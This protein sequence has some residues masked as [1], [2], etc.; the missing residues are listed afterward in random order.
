M[1]SLFPRALALA[2]VVAAG[3]ASAAI[4]LFGHDGFHGARVTLDAARAR[5]PRVRLQR[6]RV[7]G[8]RRGRVL[9]GLPGR[10]LPQPLRDPRAGQLPQPRRRRPGRP[11]VVRAPDAPQPP[12]PPP[13]CRR[14]RRSNDGD[15]V[16]FE[17]PGFHGR[18]LAVNGEI[19][20]M[21]QY[22]FNDR[23]SSVIVFEDRWE[24]CEHANFGG[25]CMILRP[26]RYPD[27]GAMGMNDRISSVRRIQHDA[28]VDD[29]RYAPPPLPAYD[30]RRRPQ[31]FVEAVP[32][33]SV[34]VVYAAP[35]MQQQCWVE[36]TAAPANARTGGAL[37]GGLIGGIL[38]HQIGD[39]QPRRHHRRRRRRRRGDRLADRPRRRPA[40]GGHALHQRAGQPGART[41]TTC[42][43]VPRR[44]PPRADD[45]AARPD[46]RRQRRRRTADLMRRPLVSAATAAATA[47]ALA[48]P[49]AVCT[50]PIS[51]ISTAGRSSSA[52]ARRKLHRRPRC[53]PP[54]LRRRS[55][56]STAAA[57]PATIAIAS[58][59]AVPTDRNIVIDGG[60]KVTLDGGGRTRLL[61]SIREN[62][63]TSRIGLTLQHITLANGKAAGTRYVAPS[64]ATRSAPSAGRTGA[65][66]RSTSATRCCTRST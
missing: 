32:I 47:A 39:R 38:G 36:Q 10:R 1:T 29:D 18:D 27:L 61:R 43:L 3:H 35:Q 55:S 20:N 5:L 64:P 23:A 4:T 52:T 8:D 56:P 40:A 62:F 16:F 25:R 6:P 50:A 22:G 34:H 66:A 31:E 12:P 21:T 41:T 44:A 30:W 58:T 19:D 65:A 46:D 45:A 9:G 26:G 17:H 60:G 37:V 33:E 13:T 48:A 28:R 54:S 57:P 63:R 51:A 59:I 14:L 53:T 11:A 24:V 2:A 7:L 49:T 15:I 42:L